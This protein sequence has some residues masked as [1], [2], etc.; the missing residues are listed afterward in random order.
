MKKYYNYFVYVSILFLIIGLIKANYLKIPIIESPFFLIL[1]ILFVCAGFFFD[2]VAWYKSVRAG[3][4][5]MVNLWDCV[6]SVGLSIFGKYVP[7]KI[8]IIMGRSAYLAK[9]YG[10]N[11]KDTTVYSLNA[12]FI[13]LWVGLFIGSIGLF[14]IKTESF[15]ILLTIILWILLSFLLFSRVVHNAV[16]SVIR[17]ILKKE[18]NI[19][20]L[21][22]KNVIKITPWFFIN[23]SCWCLGFYF[24]AQSMS[25]QQISIYTGSIFALAGTMGILAIIAPGG[26]GIR[27]GILVTM[28][29]MSGI[30]ESIAISISITSRLWFLIGEI[31]IFLMGFVVNLLLKKKSEKN[32]LKRIIG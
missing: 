1:S 10:L 24:L 31:F 32:S 26:I 7:G 30:N 6:A 12:Q 5:K 13:S 27:E 11:E 20:S 2:S 21:S 4:Y 23:W 29:I 8:W 3:G 18:I 19:P 15:L 9:K 22:F 17:K 16:T 25:A 28:L 14:F